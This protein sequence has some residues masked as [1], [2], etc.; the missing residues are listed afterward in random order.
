MRSNAVVP[1]ASTKAL[2][3]PTWTISQSTPPSSSAAATSSAS[4]L[5]SSRWR[6]RALAVSPTASPR[7][8]GLV[9][10]SPEHP[11]PRHRLHEIAEVDGFHYE[12][13]DAQGVA[14]DEV[15]LL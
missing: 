7:R 9:H 4:L 8:R 13:V 10:D 15:A 12:G 6:M 3:V 14:L 11:Q 5:S 1:R 2:W